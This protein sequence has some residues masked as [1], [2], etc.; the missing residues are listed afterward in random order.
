MPTYHAEGLV[1]KRTNY[2]EADQILTIFTKNRGKVSAIAKGSR[3]LTSRK[4][5][6][7]ELLNHSIFSLAEG[8][9]LYI[10]TEAETIEPFSEIKSDLDKSS[11]GYYL[12]EFIDE[13]LPEAQRS[14]PF[15]RLCLMALGYLND[16]E[17][18]SSQVLIHAFE[19]KALTALGFAPEIR[20]C[21]ICQ[22]PLT[23]GELNAFSPEC[24]GVVCSRCSNGDGFRLDE[25]LVE[26]LRE[27][28]CLPWKKINRIKARER[29]LEDLRTITRSY[30]EYVLEKRLESST[31]LEKIRNG[32][33]EPQKA[34]S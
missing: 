33:F 1:I 14:Y 16:A 15:F 9:S 32:R 26:L 6:H 27:V 25:D 11:L 24:G 22:Q 13:F 23:W 28:T 20:K 10:I 2:S 29:P 12:A 4:G 34:V 8:K 5:G 17:E 18:K 21:V 31:L 3:K 30:V 7:L 19:L